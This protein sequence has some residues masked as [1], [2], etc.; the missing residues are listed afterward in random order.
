MATRF[1]QFSPPYSLGA[2]LAVSEIFLLITTPPESSLLLLL[3]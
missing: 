3:D 1:A 2:L